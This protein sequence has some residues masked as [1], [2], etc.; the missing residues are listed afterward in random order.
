MRK[1]QAEQGAAAA[2]RIVVTVFMEEIIKLNAGSAAAEKGREDTGKNAGGHGREEEQAACG[3]SSRE[4]ARNAADAGGVTENGKENVHPKA[5]PA[6]SETASIPESAGTPESEEERAGKDSARK[7][8]EA[9]RS[10]IIEEAISWIKSFVLMFAVALFLTQFIIINAVI[11]SGSMEDTIMTHD[12]L[13]GTRF[14]Y[15]FSEPARGDIVIFHYPVDEKKIYIKRIIGLPGETVRIEDGNIYIDDAQEPL[16]EGYLKEE[17]EV[18]NS[19]FEFHV[20]EGSYLMLGDNRNW[21][22]DARY[23]AENAVFEELAETIEEAEPYMYVRKEKILG[24]A[25]FTYFRKFRILKHG[26]WYE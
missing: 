8:R 4:E 25:V 12:R 18:L 6:V 2:F 24:K 1:K 5:A 15:W 23:W 21:S 13:I 19:G 10:A 14:S 22:E 3:E 26:E 16:Q 9:R 20:P 17:W 7:K 11:P